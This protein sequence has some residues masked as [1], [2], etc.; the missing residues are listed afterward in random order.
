LIAAALGAMVYQNPMKE[1][2]WFPVYGIPP[3]D[4]SVFCFPES[5]KVF[6]W[7]GETFELASRRNT[8]GKKQGMYKPSI[9][10]G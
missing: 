5:L 10:T 6:H 7:H 2:G 3:S 1:I 9:S 4:K 8:P